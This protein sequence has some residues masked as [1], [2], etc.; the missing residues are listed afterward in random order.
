[1]EF[2][3]EGPSGD[4]GADPATKETATVYLPRFEEP[5]AKGV[6]KPLFDELHKADGEA[7][8]GEDDAAGDGI[9]LFSDP[10]RR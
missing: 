2:A 6:W 10:R 5:A 3:G 8:A 7:G 1:M 4:G 9:G